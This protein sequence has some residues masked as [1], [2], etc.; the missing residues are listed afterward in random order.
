MN[1]GD[2]LACLKDGMKATRDG[3]Q[4]YGMYVVLDPNDLLVL[5]THKGTFTPWGVVSGDLLGED[6]LV[7][8]SDGEITWP[9]GTVVGRYTEP[10][11]IPHDWHKVIVA[12][13]KA[14]S[15]HFANCKLGH[16][17][18]DCRECRGAFDQAHHAVHGAVV[19]L[20]EQGKVIAD[21]DDAKTPPTT[22]ARLTRKMPS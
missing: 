7:A 1:F 13:A 4:P 15:T 20:A 5:R 10:V 6:W 12:A 17:W 14:S 8:T 16:T 11:E 22:T 2:A 3:W 19:A 18:D 21:R 9:D